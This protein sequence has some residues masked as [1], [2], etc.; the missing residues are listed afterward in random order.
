MR[1]FFTSLV[2]LGGLGVVAHAQVL[3]GEVDL[4]TR[5]IMI[6]NQVLNPG[7]KISYYSYVNEQPANAD[8]IPAALIYGI[9]PDGGIFPEADTFLILNPQRELNADGTMGFYVGMNHQGVEIEAGP[10]FTPIVTYVDAVENTDSINTLL[11]ISFFEENAEPGLFADMMVRRSE[12]VDG[13]TYGYYC[14]MRPY[15]SWEEANYT[16]PR[17]RNN[18]SYTPVIWNGGGTS[19]A[20]LVKKTQYTP[21]E[22]FPNPSTDKISFNIEVAPENRSTVVRVLDNMGRVVSSQAYKG[23]GSSYSVDVA[24]FAAGTYHLQVIC[25]RAIFIN[26]FVKN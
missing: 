2:A 1:K 20:E 8:S 3:P 26:K 10:T 4:E 22:I 25:D 5:A 13:Q 7:V 23:A 18:W 6:E 17:R 19:L 21:V 16:D 24:A 12:L 9:A 11:K 14:H 15:P